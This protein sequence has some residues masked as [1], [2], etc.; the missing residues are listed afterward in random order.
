MFC[1][2]SNPLN[3]NLGEEKWEDGKVDIKSERT[4]HARRKK[5]P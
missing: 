2:K 5:T 1:V 3:T 4:S